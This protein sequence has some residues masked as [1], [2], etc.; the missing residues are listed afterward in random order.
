MET[1]TDTKS[2]ITLG[3]AILSYKTL[4]FIVVTT[5]SSAFSPVMNKSQKAALVKTYTNR[6]DPQL[7]SLLL[8]HITHHLTVLTST[9]SSFI[10]SNFRNWK[11][12]ALSGS[13]IQPN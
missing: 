10:T 12:V 13:K 9:V 8:K 4:F 7:R 11:V 5:I 3:R 6:S 1:T 2:N